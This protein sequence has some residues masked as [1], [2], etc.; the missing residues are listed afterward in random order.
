[1]KKLIALLLAVSLTT[2]SV[3]AF[4]ASFLKAA[5]VQPTATAS[6]AAIKDDV[7]TKLDIVLLAFADTTSSS[8]N[9]DFSSA[10][11]TIISKNPNAVYILSLGGENAKSSNFTQANVQT[12]ISNISSQITAFN[13]QMTSGKISGVDLDL[14]NAIEETVISELASGFKK[15]GY[16][17]SVAPQVYTSGGD[18][19]S[20][21]KTLVLTSGW[22][23]TTQSCPDTYMSAIKSGNV[24]Y[25]MAQTYNSSGFKIG[26]YSENEVGFF[27][28]VS[29]AFNNYPN[30][31]ISIFVVEGMF[32]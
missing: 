31:P 1:M 19:T 2:A 18:I 28:A 29:V 15:L 12:I 5:Y 3:F 26:G 10:I 24:D 21:T 14:E 27:E 9:S 6:F 20:S 25:I 22:N 7:Y 17:V 4:D 13:S 23:S 32:G 16:T 11:K 8:M 30:I